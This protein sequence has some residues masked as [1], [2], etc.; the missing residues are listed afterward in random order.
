MPAEKSNENQD[1]VT[2]TLNPEPEPLPGPSKIRS[3]SVSLTRTKKPESPEIT[4]PKGKG[5]NKR[6]RD[7]R[8]PKKTVSDKRKLFEDKL[9]NKYKAQRSAKEK[10]REL[11]KVKKEKSKKETP[12]EDNS[13]A[14]LLREMRND[15][16]EIKSDNREIK[17]NRQDINTKVNSIEAKQKV[18]DEKNEAEFKE[19]RNEIIANNESMQEKITANVIA[20][21]NSIINA[22]QENIIKDDVHKIVEEAITKLKPVSIPDETCSDETEDESE[23]TTQGEPE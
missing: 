23:A 6:K 4:C 16:K 14:A 11:N 19:I 21:L 9:A 13:I 22:K 12:E 5:T 10:L 17:T 20:E 15:I 18:S 7:T 8:S 3:R 1:A 2:I